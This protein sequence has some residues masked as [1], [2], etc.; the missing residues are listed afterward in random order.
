MISFIDVNSNFIVTLPAIR[1]ERTT[2]AGA[3]KPT[4]V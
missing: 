4:K 2:T 3:I 1:A